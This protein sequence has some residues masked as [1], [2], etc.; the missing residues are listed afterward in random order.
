[1]PKYIT[2]S[3]KFQ[4][5][6]PLYKYKRKIDILRNTNLYCNFKTEVKSLHSLADKVYFVS[7]CKLLCSD[8]QY[9]NQTT[10]R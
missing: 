4:I 6:I 8:H 2:I 3:Q 9:K 7:Y 1:M 10:V 5:F